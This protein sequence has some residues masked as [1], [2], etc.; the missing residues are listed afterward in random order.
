MPRAAFKTCKRCKRHA[1]EV[2]PISWERYCF[3]CGRIVYEENIR[4]LQ[5]HSGPFAQHHRR[6]CVAA[7]GG[8]LPEDVR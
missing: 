6:Q 8:V 3:P 5:A 1:S 4:Q 2:G 7:F